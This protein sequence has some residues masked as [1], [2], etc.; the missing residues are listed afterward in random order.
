M[1]TLAQYDSVIEKCRAIFT[2]KNKDYG[3][4]W[5]ILRP[6]S[7]YDQIFIKAKRIRTIEEKGQSSVDEGIDSEF[8]GII[9]YCVIALIQLKMGFDNEE[10]L[11]LEALL[12]LYNETVQQTRELM[13]AKNSDYGEAWRDMKVSTFTDMMLVRLLRIN[14]INENQGSTQVSEGV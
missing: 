11:S 7:I 13:L 10:E 5:R 9:N 8:R 2:A 12:K 1:D 6:S 4:S 3:T 14:Q